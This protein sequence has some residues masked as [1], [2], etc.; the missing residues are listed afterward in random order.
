MFTKDP[1]APSHLD[2]VA[3]VHGEF[4]VD[5]V[6]HSVTEVKIKAAYMNGATGDTFGTVIFPNS[7][8]RQTTLDALR[9]FIELA[10]EDLGRTVFGE[11]GVENVHPSGAESELGF[12]KPLGR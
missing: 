2:S 9:T 7:L 11:G 3:C 4:S 5:P 10:E 1:N 8:L 12:G 6:A